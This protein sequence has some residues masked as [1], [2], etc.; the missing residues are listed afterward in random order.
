MVDRSPQVNVRVNEPSSRCVAAHMERCAPLALLLLAGVAC[1][2][3]QLAPV[4]EGAPALEI[5]NWNLNYGLAGH[6]DALA[7]IEDVDADVVVLQETSP[8]WEAALRHTLARRYRHMT[9]HHCCGAGGLAVLSKHRIVDEEVLPAVS[10]FPAWRGVIDTD[11]G[12][13]QILDVHLRPSFDDDGSIPGGLIKTPAIR[14]QE[15]EHFVAMLDDTLPTVIAGDFNEG[16]GGAVDIVK[17]RGMASALDRAA[18]ST[19]T[20]RWQGVPFR[21]R[22]DH[23]FFDDDALALTAADVLEAGPSDHFPIVARFERAA[24]RAEKT[25][26]EPTSSLGSLGSVG[27]VGSL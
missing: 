5:L 22:L 16:S 25:P 27:S 4:H 2:G 13:V 7:L 3:P 6:E 10:W 8:D 20:W 18:V 14:R 17:A 21:L 23:V 19:P 15:M 1:T 9:F 24:P 11:L 26:D 12:R